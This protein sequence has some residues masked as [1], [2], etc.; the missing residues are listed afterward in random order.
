M[1]KCS[2]SRGLNFWTIIVIVW[3]VEHL[4]NR[5]RQ[6]KLLQL[7]NISNARGIGQYLGVRM[8]QLNVTTTLQLANSNVSMIRKSFDVTT[9]LTAR[10]V[11]GESCLALED[12]LSSKK[13]IGNSRT[14]GQSI[15]KLE[16]MQQ[17]VLLYASRM[18]VKQGKQNSAVA[19]SVFP[20]LPAVNV[21]SHSIQNGLTHLRLAAISFFYLPVSLKSYIVQITASYMLLFARPLYDKFWLVWI[22]VTLWLRRTG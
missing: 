4:S 17:A 16:H 21:T 3:G 20:S 1:D 2:K 8:N 6:R 22:E 19:M 5:S 11:N 9:V 10:E 13:Q 14:F 12:E 18:A 15:T 7:T